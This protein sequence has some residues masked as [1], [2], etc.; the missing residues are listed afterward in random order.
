MLSPCVFSF[1]RAD[2]TVRFNLADTISPEACDRARLWPRHLL[3]P[4][5]R[6]PRQKV[7]YAQLSDDYECDVIT[8]RVWHGLAIR[9]SCVSLKSAGRRKD[10]L[11]SKTHGWLQSGMGNEC[12]RGRR[13]AKRVKWQ[14]NDH[15]ASGQI[16]SF[17]RWEP[18]A[19]RRSPDV[20]WRCR[21]R[22]MKTARKVS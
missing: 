1:S 13:A 20:P 12:L 6:R 22:Y 7:S 8:N 21:R 16:L 5:S 9:A 2:H 10:V 11:M 3:K 19:D 4:S 18:R 14:K 15:L 17:G